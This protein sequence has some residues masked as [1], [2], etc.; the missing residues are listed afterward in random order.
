MTD[1]ETTIR[2]LKN[3]VRKFRAD[4]QWAKYH[5]AKNLSMSIAIEAGELM[6][7]FQWVNKDGPITPEIQDELADIAIYVLSF[8]EIY[9]IDLASAIE[10]KMQANAEK[11]PVQE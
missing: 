3:A 2:A 10:S 9:S 5:T 1:K 8:C 6:E 11:Y 4:R 7:H